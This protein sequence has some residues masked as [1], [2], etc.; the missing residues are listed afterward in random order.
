MYLPE[1]IVEANKFVAPDYFVYRNMS[2]DLISGDG[3]YTY[4]SNVPE[5]E[6]LLFLSGFVSGQI[7]DRRN[8]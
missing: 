3:Y 2:L 5:R 7:Y 8:K 4:V 6:A 1:F